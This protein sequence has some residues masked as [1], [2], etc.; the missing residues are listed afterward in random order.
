LFSLIIK[1]FLKNHHNKGVFE[2]IILNF[3]SRE[4]KLVIIF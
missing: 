1:Q 2:N 3:V 4:T